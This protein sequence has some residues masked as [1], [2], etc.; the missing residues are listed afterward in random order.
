MFGEATLL[1]KMDSKTS[2][3]QKNTAVAATA[4]Q[5]CRSRK[6][7]PPAA[8]E[9][10]VVDVSAPAESKQ[11]VPATMF[12][13]EPSATTQDKKRPAMFE[14][15]DGPEITMS[16][17]EERY[18]DDDA[19]DISLSD[20]EME[21]MDQEEIETPDIPD[22]PADFTME[23]RSQPR[24][25]VV[26][27]HSRF[28]YT[29]TYNGYENEKTV[30]HTLFVQLI[31]E[32][33]GI[34]QDTMTPMIEIIGNKK[35]DSWVHPFF[36]IRNLITRGRKTANN[37]EIHA[38]YENA[39]N[40]VI[41]YGCKMIREFF[42]VGNDDVAIS[43]SRHSH[44]LSDID[45]MVRFVLFSK[46][47]RFSKLEKFIDYLITSGNKNCSEGIFLHRL[48]NTWKNTVYS[49]YKDG[50]NVSA[51][52]ALDPIDSNETALHIIQVPTYIIGSFEIADPVFEDIAPMQVQVTPAK[53]LIVEST[54][55]EVRP[56]KKQAVAP[57]SGSGIVKGPYNEIKHCPPLEGD[58]KI[59][60]EDISEKGAKRFYISPSHEATIGLIHSRP[61]GQRFF[62]EWYRKTD[63]VRLIFD[64]ETEH[65]FYMC[66]QSRMD[67]CITDIVE[68]HNEVASEL[69]MNTAN[70]RWCMIAGTKPGKISCHL[71]C[72]DYFDSWE[73]QCSYVKTYFS[74]LFIGESNYLN[75]VDGAIY[76]TVGGR[77]MRMIHCSKMKNREYP[78]V[79]VKDNYPDEY[80]L[81]TN[82]TRDCFRVPFDSL[83]TAVIKKNWDKRDKREITPDKFQIETIQECI[84][85]N[86]DRFTEHVRDYNPWISVGFRMASAGLDSE[87][88]HLV[89]ALD[90]KYKREDCESKWR[91]IVSAV[92]DK[93]KNMRSLLY[94]IKKILQI[95][96]N[97]RPNAG[98]VE[99]FDMVSMF[100]DSMISETKLGTLYVSKEYEQYTIDTFNRFFGVVLVAKPEIFMVRYDQKGRMIE[101][102]ERYSNTSFKIAFEPISIF[103]KFWLR[104]RYR[105]QFQRYV[106][107][108]DGN[109]ASDEFNLFTGWKVT[110]DNDLDSMT[111]DMQRVDPFIDHVLNVFCRGDTGH[112]DYFLNWLSFIVQNPGKKTGVVVVLKSVNQGAGKGLIVDVLLGNGVF[113][114]AAY[115]QVRNIEGL[116]GKFNSSLMNKQF[117]N[118]DEVSMNKKEAN[119]VKSMVTEPYME[120]EKKGLDKI[121]LKNLMNFVFTS[122]NEFCVN[123]DTSDRRY[124]ILDVDDSNANNHEFF[125]PF[126]KYCSDPLTAAHVFMYLKSRDIS[127]FNVR[128]IPMTKEK[129]E[130]LQA[131]IPLPVRFV[132]EYVEDAV[133][134]ETWD[135]RKQIASDHLYG[136]FTQ[137]LTNK[138]IAR[139]CDMPKFQDCL[140]KRL[141]LKTIKKR[142][143][144][145]G[146]LRFYTFP[147]DPNE[148]I[149]QMKKSKLY[150][151]E[152]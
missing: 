147:D 90:R 5:P 72:S 81:A 148:F 63:R 104:N 31:E 101:V 88:F 54:A 49:K 146:R 71:L 115:A 62:Y 87:D 28:N 106:F 127:N 77:A 9:T 57:A 17:I 121:R 60:A 120:F 2:F 10:P 21:F 128:D 66:D 14:E 43:A 67:I 79:P 80:Y 129:Q 58:E 102:S 119:E 132:Q 123:L 41:N 118:V 40:D 29:K 134:T 1:T 26:S 150:T 133:D 96:V 103:V 116:I 68:R 85:E 73:I 53:P 138:N 108:P 136:L 19:P 113:G 110:L 140:G 92:S 74:D 112:C 141:R 34:G 45:V 7:L 144:I 44:N 131:A 18:D 56:M 143:G 32:Y 97:L 149:D 94:F 36:E 20:T 91:N 124:F 75:V 59:I 76:D 3:V 33:K 8:P 142:D 48:Y 52:T 137:Y 78:M 93:P 12:V 111:L 50:Q 51:W 109:N 42:G 15:E 47:I 37:S 84:R 139:Q 30:D 130:Y 6:S 13:D 89:S 82:I 27:P 61:E 38:L 145:N 39:K 65:D 105:R 24:K 46:R 4:F 114:H 86:L 11:V 70:T 83:K 69:G 99:K 151:Y 64:I 125:I 35:D 126:S 98:S 135:T 23:V 16:D 95:P 117:V 100:N 152:L 107:E 25:V 55:Q 22:I 122:N